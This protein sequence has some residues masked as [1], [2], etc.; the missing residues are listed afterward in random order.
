MLTL[1]E[2]GCDKFITLVRACDKFITYATNTKSIPLLLFAKAARRPPWRV[3]MY[4]EVK[5]SLRLSVYTS[6]HLRF[7]TSTRPGIRTCRRLSSICPYFQ[8]S[9]RLYFY[10]LRR[11]YARA[12]T[13]LD[14][15][16]PGC[17]DVRASIRMDVQMYERLYAWMYRCLHTWI[18]RCTDV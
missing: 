4:L 18:P 14:V 9:T 13:L 10:T 12:Y 15:Y 7:H 1:H 5:K 3:P 6:I 16:T 11:L 17:T 2:C 8:A